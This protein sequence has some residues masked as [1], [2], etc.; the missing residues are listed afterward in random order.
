MIFSP[1]IRVITVSGAFS[2]NLIRSE[3]SAMGLPFRVL[4]S[5]YFEY[6]RLAAY[7]TRYTAEQS[8]SR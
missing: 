4:I 6:Y 8:R 2:T 3:F 5:D 1:L 7:L